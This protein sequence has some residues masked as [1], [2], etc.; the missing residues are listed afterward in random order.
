MQHTLIVRLVDITLLLLL[1]LMAIASIDPFAVEP[2]LSEAIEERGVMLQPLQVAIT[3]EGTIQ[4]LDEAGQ[5]E[6]HSA[7]EAAVRLMGTE[8]GIEVIAD[9]RASAQ[10]L[11]SLHQALEAQGVPAAFLAER[12]NQN[13]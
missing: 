13:P 1:S 5:P 4:I 8:G 11:L 7:E 9:H 6:A 12:I 10:L 2:P 3:A